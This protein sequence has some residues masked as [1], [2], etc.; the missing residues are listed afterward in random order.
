MVKI[1]IDRKE[2][3]VPDGMSVLGAARMHGI[4]VPSMCYREGK[5]HFTS[6]MIC[7]VKDEKNGKLFPS[8]SVKA[9]DGMEIITRDEEVEESRRMALELLLS[10]HVGDCEA[11]CQ[12][13]CPAH[14]DIPLM[15]R[16][17]ADGKFKEALKV[18]RQDI[19]L[20]AVF[21]RICP[22]PCEG[23]CRRKSI[24]S[25]VSICLL[26]RYA[27]DHDLLGD[28]TTV[29]DKRPSTGK[30]V[31]IIGAG[32][33]GLAAAY[34]LQLRGH[35][36][37]VYD[38]RIY[39]GGSLWSEVENGVLEEDVLRAEIS[40][41]EKL[42][43]QFHNEVRVDAG[44]YKELLSEVDAIVLAGGE[45]K[46]GS[47]EL[48]GYGLELTARGVEVDA[49]TYQTSNPRVFAAGSVIRPAKLAIRTL[50]HGK[51]VAFSVDQY[52]SGEEVKGE[53]VIF[54]SRFGKLID[55]ELAEYLKESN[56]GARLEPEN[57]SDG[58]TLEQV[59]EEAARCLHCDCRE[60]NNCKLRLLSEEYNA[61]Q[62]HYWPE[63]RKVV[64]KH[65]QHDLVIYEPN[66]CIKCGICVHIT[67]EYKEKFGLSFIGR[68]F[69][70]V[71]GVPF[72]EAL[73]EGLVEV[74]ELVI[75]SCPTGAMSRRKA[76][77]E[78]KK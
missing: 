59:K 74:A 1:K 60:L 71:I 32:P 29:G 56:D 28:S 50:G 77:N 45:V 15:N 72:G 61:S 41:I 58:F 35:S 4:D 23:A 40:I 14:M 47:D 43:V 37:D 5:P 39:A 3:Q 52:V 46:E 13:T 34:Y 33:A 70:V 42:G 8:C 75:E 67:E 30:R 18:V 10:E 68:G 26:K 12:V 22:A 66:K 53:P 38:S 27:G 55:G 25:A 54:N 48:K 17:L 69:D 7:M 57:K 16:L 2:F 65:V 21:G 20:P 24:D 44:K 62:K 51:E 6:C 78:K 11:P 49:K 36:C 64:Q 9:M 76:G 63:E 19:A 31:A 73:S